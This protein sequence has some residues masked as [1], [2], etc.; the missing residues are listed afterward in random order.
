MNGD[1]NSIEVDTDPSPN[2]PPVPLPAANPT[3]NTR[4]F[5]FYVE[6]RGVP[7]PGVPQNAF[8]DETVGEFRRRTGYTLPLIYNREY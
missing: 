5:R 1:N 7:P 2:P 8:L 4:P 3:N 6:T